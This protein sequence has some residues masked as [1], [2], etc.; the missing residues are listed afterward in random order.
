ME[1]SQQEP[2]DSENS[3]KLTR[4]YLLGMMPGEERTVF[5]KRYVVD[6]DL[7]DEL[8]AEETELIDS[9]VRGELSP[10]DRRRCEEYLLSA[11][12]LQKRLDFSRSLM[13]LGENAEP[14]SFEPMESPEKRSRLRAFLSKFGLKRYVTTAEASIQPQ[15]RSL[16]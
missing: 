1:T 11:P 9:Y 12:E 16:N 14:G 6:S 7:F 2:W 4:R 3:Q 13:C 10:E 5:E 15:F 8:Q